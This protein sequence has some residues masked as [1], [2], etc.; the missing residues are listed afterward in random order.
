M[1]MKKVGYS[2]RCI[3]A[4]VFRA[5]TTVTVTW[6]STTEETARVVPHKPYIAHNY[7]QTHWVTFLSFDSLGPASVILTKLAPKGVALHKIKRNDHHWAVQVQ[8]HSRLPIGTNRKPFSDFLY[9]ALFRVTVHRHGHTGLGESMYHG[10][11]AVA[12][13]TFSW[14]SSA[15]GPKGWASIIY[16]TQA[17]QNQLSD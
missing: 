7:R 2:S 11:P 17:A 4:D 10:H 6:S 8:G 12:F 15:L 16:H 5:L 3:I 1:S 13:R 14:N 9:L